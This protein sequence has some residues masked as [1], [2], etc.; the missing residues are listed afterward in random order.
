MTIEFID[1]RDAPGGLGPIWQG[2][3]DNDTPALQWAIDQGKATGGRVMLPASAVGQLHAPIDCTSN[4]LPADRS[5]TI[6]GYGNSWGG[7]RVILVTGTNAVGFDC[8]GAQRISLRRFWYSMG[9]QLFAGL[10]ISASTARPCDKTLFSELR[11]DGPT[12]MGAFYAYAWGSSGVRFWGRDLWIKD[13]I[14]DAS[15]RLSLAVQVLG[16]VKDHLVIVANDGKLPQAEVDRLTGLAWPRRK[17]CGRPN[18]PYLCRSFLGR[19]TDR[20]RRVR[21]GRIRLHPMR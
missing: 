8:V 3:A 5:L 18:A 19:A 7:S 9:V 13:M 11:G 15:E 20:T 1:P 16:V 6:E 4:N 17:G 10:V 12:A 14:D 21:Y 2:N